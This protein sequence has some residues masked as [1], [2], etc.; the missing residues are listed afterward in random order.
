MTDGEQG[1]RD[2]CDAAVVDRR[3]QQHADACAAAHPVDEADPVRLQRSTGTHC[4]DVR[5]GVDLQVAP[6]PADEQPDR[7]RR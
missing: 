6:A 1:E 4:M 7:E 2:H 5:M 3:E